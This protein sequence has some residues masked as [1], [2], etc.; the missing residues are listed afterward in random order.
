VQGYLCRDEAAIKA[1]VADA[2]A[3]GKPALIQVPVA[4]VI[5]PYMHYI[6]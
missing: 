3:S 4:S 2:I 6:S 1:A 5:S